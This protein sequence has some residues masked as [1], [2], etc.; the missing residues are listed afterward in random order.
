MF[1][2]AL[3][4]FDKKNYVSAR[5]KFN[6]LKN[7]VSDD[8]S[9]YYEADFYLIECTLSE[10]N[11]NEAKSLLESM[12]VDIRLP[13]SVLE[14][15]LVRLGQIHCSRNDKKAATMHFTRLADINP[16]SIY[17]KIANCDFINNSSK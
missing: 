2:D 10:N 14:R 1:E 13:N 6:A 16:N 9:L 15:V 17:L 5:Q 11:L 7:T 3:N 12:L 4:D 8:D